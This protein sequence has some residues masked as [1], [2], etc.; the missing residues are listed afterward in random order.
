MVQNGEKCNF[1][2]DFPEL[3]ESGTFASKQTLRVLSVNKARNKHIPQQLFKEI[4][5]KAKSVHAG[6]KLKKKFNFWQTFQGFKIAVFNAIYFEKKCL[7]SI[8]KFHSTF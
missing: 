1:L 5:F 7:S 6:L 4:Y 3:M 8:G 2:M